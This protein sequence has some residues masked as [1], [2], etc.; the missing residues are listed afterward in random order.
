[1]LSSQSPQKLGTKF[2]TKNGVHK[3]TNVKNTTPN[4][5]VAFCSSR[6]MRPC[7]DEFRDMTLEFREWWDRIVAPRVIK[8]GA[9][10]FVAFGSPPLA[11][12]P[13][14][15]P[16]MRLWL[17]SV[18]DRRNGDAIVGTLLGVSS[19]VVLWPPKLEPRRDRWLRRVSHVT[20]EFV[21]PCADDEK[22]IFRIG[23]GCGDEAGVLVADLCSG[24]VDVRW[25]ECVEQP[26]FVDRIDGKS[27]A[28]V[29]DTDFTNGPAA[30]L[31]LVAISGTSSHP[32]VAIIFTSVNGFDWWPVFEPKYGQVHG[33]GNTISVDFVPFDGCSWTQSTFLCFSFESRRFLSALKLSSLSSVSPVVLGPSPLL[34]LPPSIT[35]ALLPQASSPFPATLSFVANDSSKSSAVELAPPSSFCSIRDKLLNLFR[36]PV[37]SLCDSVRGDGSHAECDARRFLYRRGDNG[38]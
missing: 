36:K 12:P 17:R 34:S 29:L 7:R 20:T 31:L 19:N 30:D 3:I 22:L 15:T 38:L 28:I 24:D 4:T 21:L 32:L 26:F 6:M 33:G 37:A 1:M 10:L 18:A 9:D 27:L 35:Q 11:L 16:L 25:S 8:H 23:T 2:K 14:F 5:F 13:T